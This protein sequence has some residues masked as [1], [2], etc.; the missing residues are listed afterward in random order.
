[1]IRARP[2]PAM[3]PKFITAE[4]AASA[5]GDQVA[6]QGE[7]RRAVAGLADADAMREG[8]QARKLARQPAG[9]GGEAP[10][11]SPT[12]ISRLRCRGRR[13][14]RSAA[15]GDGGRRRPKAKPMI[16]LIWVS[17]IC[18]S[19]LDERHQQG[20]NAASRKFTSSEERDDEDG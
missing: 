13:S 18:R 6:E 20:D 7:A 10:I 19:G 1:M 15:A 14:A 12:A 17:L 2:L 5:R 16:R 8:E 4:P 3:K 9:G 11:S